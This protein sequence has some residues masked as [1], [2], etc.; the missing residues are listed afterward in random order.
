[1][2]GN[3][4]LFHVFKLS[5]TLP[6]PRTAAIILRRQSAVDLKAQTLGTNAMAVHCWQGQ[7][8]SILYKETIN[9]V[10]NDIQRGL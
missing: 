8:G 10:Q 9:F 6:A 1:M 5:S 4:A 2:S 7:A 3:T